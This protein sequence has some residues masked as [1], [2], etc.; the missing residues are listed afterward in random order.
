MHN[1]TRMTRTRAGTDESKMRPHWHLEAQ[2]RSFLGCPNPIS[3]F[4]PSLVCS[5]ARFVCWQHALTGR[6]PSYCVYLL[7]VLC[8]RHHARRQARAPGGGCCTGRLW[9]WGHKIQIIHWQSSK[10]HVTWR[11]GGLPGCQWVEMQWGVP[12][13]PH[14]FHKLINIPIILRRALGVGG[15]ASEWG[16]RGQTP[17]R[18]LTPRPPLPVAVLHTVRCA[19]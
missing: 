14:I 17:V 12:C 19:H 2:N 13:P 16:A 6:V 3:F 7:H 4:P 5:G 11:G 15:P 1:D 18:P 9:Q 10:I 8:W